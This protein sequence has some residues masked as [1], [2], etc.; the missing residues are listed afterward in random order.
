M[1]KCRKIG[2]G[3]LT[4]PDGMLDGI[5]DELSARFAG[6][7]G[8]MRVEDFRALK[9]PFEENPDL[10]AART[11]GRQRDPDSIVGQLR[12]LDIGESRVFAKYRTASQLSA[13]IRAARAHTG[14]RYS[15]SRELSLVDGDCIGVRVTR[16]S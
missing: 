5:T 16:V 6:L 14:A 8:S 1:S 2:A 9:H 11:P 12:A 7:D 13:N 4:I 3:P 10:G 15:C